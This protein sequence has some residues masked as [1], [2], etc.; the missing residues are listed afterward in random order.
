MPDFRELFEE[1]SEATTLST[2]YLTDGNQD[3][4]VSIIIGDIG[5]SGVSEVWLDDEKI[6]EGVQGSFNY[7][8]NSDTLRNKTLNIYTIVTDTSQNSNYTE[9]GLHITGGV[10]NF[11]N[12]LHKEVANDGESVFYENEIFFYQ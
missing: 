11:H 9:V 7:H 4:Q 2:S 5:R 3:I 10:S 1:S 6:M 12:R 8:N